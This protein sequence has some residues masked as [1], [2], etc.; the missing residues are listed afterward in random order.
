MHRH[1][2]IGRKFSRNKGPR[3]ALFRSLATSIILYEKV[4]TTLPKAKEIRPMI[5]KLITTAKAGDLNA[6]RELNTVLYDKKAVEKLL[7]ELAPL[8]KERKGGY[9]RIVKVGNRMGDNAPMA[10]IELLDVEKLVAKEKPVKTAKTTEA[11]PKTTAKAPAKNK[12]AAST[13]AKASQD[14]KETK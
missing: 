11:K 9:T 4:K 14:K 7:K 2:N 6:L 5:E 8:Y 13:S 3:K 10:I 1:I 12:A